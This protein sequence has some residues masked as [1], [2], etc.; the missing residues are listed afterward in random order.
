MLLTGMTGQ[1]WINVLVNVYLMEICLLHRWCAGPLRSRPQPLRRRSARLP[2]A[3][4]FHGTQQVKGT[5]GQHG[6]VVR[7]LMSSAAQ[8]IRGMNP[9]CYIQLERMGCEA[10][11][12]SLRRA[13]WVCPNAGFKQ[14][15]E[16]WEALGWDLDAWPCP[17]SNRWPKPV[18]LPCSCT[19]LHS[20][21]NRQCNC[22]CPK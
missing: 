20:I 9:G 4:N 16:A 6:S 13:R 17:A 3:G 18:R 1:W 2:H 8:V 7:L 15:L 12:A 5:H 10:A 11:L 22:N 19:V 14:Q 21:P